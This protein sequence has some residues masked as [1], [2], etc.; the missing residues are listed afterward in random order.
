MDETGIPV[1]FFMI[2]RMKLSGRNTPKPTPAPV[3]VKKT[4]EKSCDGVHGILL[5]KEKMPKDP[6][7]RLSQRICLE[8]RGRVWMVASLENRIGGT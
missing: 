8:P 3:Y 5:K 2:A 4:G 7:P 1:A 6:V